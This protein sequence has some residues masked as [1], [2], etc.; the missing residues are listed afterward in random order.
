MENV[1]VGQS[2]A[3]AFCCRSISSRSSRDSTVDQQLAK[4]WLLNLAPQIESQKNNESNRIPIFHVESLPK[5]VKSF[6][7]ML[8]SRFKS[9]SRFGF[10]QHCILYRLRNKVPS[11]CSIWSL[12][13][14]FQCH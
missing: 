13:V 6:P 2:A 10:A 9:Q 11:K 4:I 14:T 8:K 1:A 5:I 3:S 12:T 7:K